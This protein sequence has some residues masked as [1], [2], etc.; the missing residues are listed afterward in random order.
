MIASLVVA[1]V[2]ATW[3][4]LNISRGL[5]RAVGLAD[6]VATGDLTKRSKL[7]SNDEVG[8]LVNR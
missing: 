2:A 1:V 6:A 3:I 8:D 7:A 4:A 5:G